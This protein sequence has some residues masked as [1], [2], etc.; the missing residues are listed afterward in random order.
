[1][2]RKTICEKREL[3]RRGKEAAQTELRRGKRVPKPLGPPES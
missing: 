1:M 3:R 2:K